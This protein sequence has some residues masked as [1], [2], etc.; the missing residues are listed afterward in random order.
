MWHTHSE[1]RGASSLRRRLFVDGIGIV[2]V[3]VVVVGRLDFV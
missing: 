1:V 2:V 3:V